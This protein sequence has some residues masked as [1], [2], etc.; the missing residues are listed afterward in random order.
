M[1]TA[2][3]SASMTPPSDNDDADGNQRRCGT[4]DDQCQK[5]QKG[6]EHATILQAIPPRS[7]RQRSIC[8]AQSRSMVWTVC[9]A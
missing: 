5:N 8:G 7:Q 2:T 9:A 3:L 1:E 4:D 6:N